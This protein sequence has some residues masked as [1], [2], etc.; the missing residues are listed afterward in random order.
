VIRRALA[1]FLL[2]A[3]CGSPPHGTWAWKPGAPVGE[4][5]AELT[6]WTRGEETYEAFESRLFVKATY[7]SPRFA[8]AYAAANVERRGLPAS[9]RG[10]QMRAAAERA[11]TEARFFVTIAAHDPYWDD[12]G[13]DDATL[14]AVLLEGDAEVA[15]AHIERLSDDQKLDQTPYFPY[16]GPLTS[17]FWITFPAPADPRDVR[18]RVAGAPAVIDLHWKG[19]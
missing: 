18:L 5:G 16:L 19:R 11:R 4:Y 1:P 8:A 6:A 3:A 15:P 17:A 12:L 13:R 10:D 14:R 9:A 2:L 7:F